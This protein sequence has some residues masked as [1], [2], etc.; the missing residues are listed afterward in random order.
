MI[1]SKTAKIHSKEI[2]RKYNSIVVGHRVK[3]KVIRKKNTKK[4]V[5][6]VNS[7]DQGRVTHAIP[8]FAIQFR[9]KLDNL[10]LGKMYQLSL[11]PGKHRN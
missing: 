3:N 4:R 11:Y 10:N 9:G 8:N 5:S 7:E 6:R 1:K 2:G